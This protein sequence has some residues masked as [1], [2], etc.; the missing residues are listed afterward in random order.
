MLSD[1][2][3]QQRPPPFPM[4]LLMLT[5]PLTL[6]LA[7]VMQLVLYSSSQP[8]LRLNHVQHLRRPLPYI[9]TATT[10]G[11]CYGRISLK[12]Y[13][14]IT[15]HALKKILRLRTTAMGNFQIPMIPPTV[16]WTTIQIETRATAKK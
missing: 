5:L 7:L 2:I 3:A 12:M 6:M 15:A 13:G 4:L 10:C 1:P 14:K 16:S 11:W 9:H 8:P